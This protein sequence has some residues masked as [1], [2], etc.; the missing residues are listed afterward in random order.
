MSQA[1]LIA[2]VLANLVVA[3][4]VLLQDWGYLA[5]LVA[6]WWEAVIVG[7]FNLARIVTV[8]LIGEPFG[9]RVGVADPGSRVVLALLL[10]GFFSMKFGGFALMVGFAILASPA[11]LGGSDDAVFEALGDIAPGIPLTVGVLLISHGI[12]FVA[13]YLGRR[14]YRAGGILRLMFWPYARMGSTFLVL[15]LGLLAARFFSPLANTT[16]FALTII[17]LKL[18]GDLWTHRREHGAE[19]VVQGSGF[20]TRPG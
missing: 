20:R 17:G 4:I 13:N 15:A 3:A 7:A 1:A 16:V 14:E 8:C 12:S 2:L 9:P 6:Y 11:L 5:V 10:C 18:A 19:S